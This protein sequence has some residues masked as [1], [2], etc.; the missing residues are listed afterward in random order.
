M[1]IKKRDTQEHENSKSCF[2]REYEHQTEKLG[3]ATARINGRY[4][5]KKK[6]V[7]LESEQIFYVLSGTGEIHSDKGD[8]EISE[9]DSYH[10]ERGEKYWMQGSKLVVALMNAPKWNPDQYR[11]VD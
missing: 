8:F 3:F 4:P 6:V 2:V 7:N 10:L 11:V 9:G 1:L 5:D